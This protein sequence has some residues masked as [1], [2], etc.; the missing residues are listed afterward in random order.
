MIILPWREHFIQKNFIEYS[1]R[2]ED[3]D[4]VPDYNL[5]KTLSPAEQYYLAQNFNWDDGATVLNWIIESPKCDK[6]TA[7]LIFWSAEPIDYIQETEKTIPDYEIETFSLLQKITERFRKNDFKTAKFR[8]NP[9][10]KV[11]T[12][13]WNK[14][15]EG[16]DLPI[17]LKDEIKG[18]IPLSIGAIRYMIW[19]WQRKRKLAKRE[20]RK[21]RR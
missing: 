3:I 2:T 5:F 10:A 4:F 9:G 8:F 21:K 13:D 18:S 17:S 14:N 6:G 15:Y 16:W 7:L 19:E 20:A 12:I 11:N 1:F